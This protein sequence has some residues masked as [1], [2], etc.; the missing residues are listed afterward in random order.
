MDFYTLKGKNAN[1]FFKLSLNPN[2]YYRWSDVKEMGIN[3]VKEFFTDVEKEEIIKNIFSFQEIIDARKRREVGL[4]AKFND[5]K[6]KFIPESYLIRNYIMYG[7]KKER[8]V[9][10]EMYKMKILFEKCDITNQ[11]EKYKVD[12]KQQLYTFEEKDKFYDD[13]YNKYVKLNPRYK[14][15][16]K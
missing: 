6:I 1:N 10:K 12:T 3:R 2:K 4:R 11:W 8:E 9:L 5:Y 15:Y 7:R 14:Q 13:T 16:F